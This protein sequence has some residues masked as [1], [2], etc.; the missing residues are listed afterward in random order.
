MIWS[1]IDTMFHL[2]FSLC[3]DVN[4]RVDNVD[5]CDGD[6]LYDLWFHLVFSLRHDVNDWVDPDW[7]PVE[8]VRN[9]VHGRVHVAFVKDLIEKYNWEY[10]R[11]VQFINTVEKYNW[12]IHLGSAV[13]KYT[14]ERQWWI[15]VVKCNWEIALIIN[16]VEKCK[17][18]EAQS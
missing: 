6:K 18:T 13:E 9:Y 10:N 15:K 16:I 8:Y 5:S 2:I 12:K 4:D 17:D 3:H 7:G 11:E 14:W 1:P